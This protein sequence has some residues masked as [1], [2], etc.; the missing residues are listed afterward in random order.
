MTAFF[1]FLKIF[2][3]GSSAEDVRTESQR[4]VADVGK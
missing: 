2:L 3:L 4:S 1:V